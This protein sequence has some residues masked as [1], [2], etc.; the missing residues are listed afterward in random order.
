M[1]AGRVLALER[2]NNA[3]LI[4]YRN[5]GTPT[6]GLDTVLSTWNG[7]EPAAVAELLG[8][9]EYDLG[10]IYLLAPE[11]H[12]LG[13]ISADQ[14]DHLISDAAL[15]T[16][17]RIRSRLNDSKHLYDPDEYDEL[18]RLQHDPVAFER[19]A[20]VPG[21]A[22]HIKRPWW[23]WDVHHFH[24]TLDAEADDPARVAALSK[25]FSNFHR[26]RLERSMEWAGKRAL[27][28]YTR[29]LV[30]EYYDEDEPQLRTVFDLLA[31]DESDD[32]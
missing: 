14:R 3:V 11:A 32:L 13:F 8:L 5:D 10:G 1:A 25:A 28:G 16:E 23:R 21:L 30:H 7:L 26:Y 20:K 24:P 12:H 9:V 4:G 17:Q 15:I 2:G 29:P 27:A 6:P 31:T 19:A 18:V 22:F